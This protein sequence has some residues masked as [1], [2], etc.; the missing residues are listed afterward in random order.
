MI[1]SG[2]P[3]R[4]PRTFTHL[5][6]EFAILNVA[7]WAWLL[8]GIGHGIAVQVAIWA[9]GSVAMFGWEHLANKRYKRQ[10]RLARGLCA[11]CGYDLRES[12]VRCP[13]CGAAVPAGHRPRG[14]LA[15]DLER[16]R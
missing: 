4:R 12:G 10:F 6:G 15:S 1:P 8:F 7:V 2:P 13:E 5:A 16:V 14:G 11:S 3:A 9:C